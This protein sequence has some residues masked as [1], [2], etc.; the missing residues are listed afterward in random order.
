M[1]QKLKSADQEGNQHT[2]SSSSS[3]SVIP[4]D[5]LMRPDKI[6]G[7]YHATPVLPISVDDFFVSM[8]SAFLMMCT[9]ARVRVLCC[10]VL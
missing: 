7:A 1:K 3:S 5:R 2:S 6:A 9:C 4:T 10:V 8:C